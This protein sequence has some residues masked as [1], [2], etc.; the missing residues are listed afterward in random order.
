MPNDLITERQ[1]RLIDVALV[2]AVVALAFVVL[3]FLGGFWAAFGD[4]VLTFFLAWLLS[5]ALR[6]LIGGVQRVVP[7]L[8]QSGA[9]LVVYLSIV[10]I[11]LLVLVQVS[12]SLA[13]SINELLAD[14]PNLESSLT[15]LVTSLQ[16]R[17]TALGFQVDLVRQVPDV[18]KGLQT[19][20]TELIG[21]LQQFAV[22]SIGIFGNILMV[23]ILSIYIAI[24]RQDIGAFLLRLVPPSFGSG[25][26]LLDASV[27]R[28]FAGFLRTQL[29]MGVSFGLISFSTDV[30][31]G[32]P[33]AVVTA[34]AV[35]VLHAIPF[36]GPFVSWLPPVLVAILFK[37]EVALPVLIIMGIGWFVTMNV[38]QPRLMAGSVGIHPI[39]VLASVLIGAKIAG[40]AGAV[41]GIP[42]AAVVSAM[43]FSWFER[44]RDGVTVADRATK[45]VAA[46]EGR[47]VRRPME[48]V[49]GVDQD[50]DEVV[51][52][53][54]R[55]AHPDQAH[56]IAA[57]ADGEAQADADMTGAET[58]AS[59]E[60]PSDTAPS[61]PTSSDIATPDT[62]VSSDPGA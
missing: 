3:G 34:V 43:F 2:L 56:P 9:V 19:G 28:S 6:P 44:S 24:D 39:V 35:G 61:D 40:I 25:A 29:V 27:S 31:F 38:L 54:E 10:G 12:A 32:L 50:L 20:A 48:P 13:T 51:A 37:P 62:V 22:A 49:G 58:R 60:A 18:I 55:R 15:A 36:F 46:R 41:F 59:A 52:A 26:R 8:G 16:E 1:R 33:Y 4:L 53:R 11:M 57:A 14:L 21:P 45:R 7:R 23:V 47:P 30:V 17:L 42:I 5:F